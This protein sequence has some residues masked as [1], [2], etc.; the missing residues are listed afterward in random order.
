[1][2]LW[3][4]FLTNQGNLIYKW[5]HY[6]PIY[7]RYL[8]QFA[9]KTVLVFEIGVFKGGSLQ[10]WQRYLGPY[11]TLVGVDINQDCKRHE[12][13]GVHVRIGDQKDEKFLLGL[14]EEFGIPDIVIDDGSHRMSDILA[15]FNVL[16][17]RLSKSGIY[18]VEDLHT[19]YWP[20][21]EGGAKRPDTFV[22]LCKN[23]VDNLNADHSR[24]EIASDFITKNTIGIHFYD[25]VIVFERGTIPYKFAPRIGRDV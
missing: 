19:A 14:I 17:P 23:L 15:T 21:Y 22:N 18:I 24:G 9:N 8:S 11:A 10:L 4:E 1:M 2:S 12:G 25:S 16:Y 5:A 6:F 7:E 3:S 20:E 13:L